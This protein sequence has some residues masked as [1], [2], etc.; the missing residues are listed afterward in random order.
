MVPKLVRKFPLTRDFIPRRDYREIGAIL[1]NKAWGTQH[2][3]GLCRDLTVPFQAPEALVPVT[4][5][6]I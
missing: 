1:R 6:P 4:V 5:R 3:L 2:A